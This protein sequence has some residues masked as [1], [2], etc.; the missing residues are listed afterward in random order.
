MR[1][2]VNSGTRKTIISH[3]C[4]DNFGDRA[5]L[6]KVNVRKLASVSNSVSNDFSANAVVNV[7]CAS[8]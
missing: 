8:V 5:V 1:A 2:L 4:A 7:G 3:V 6:V